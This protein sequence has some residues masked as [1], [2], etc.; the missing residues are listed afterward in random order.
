MFYATTP[1]NDTIPNY[2]TAPNYAITPKNAI[3]PYYVPIPKYATT[4]NNES[5]HSFIIVKLLYGQWDTSLNQYN[6]TIHIIS[7]IYDCTNNICNNTYICTY[8]F[9]KLYNHDTVHIVGFCN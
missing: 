5:N 8:R 7:L 1:K 2:T 3:I 6:P 4:S 9:F